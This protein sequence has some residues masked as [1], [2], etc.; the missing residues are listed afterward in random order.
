MDAL[1]EKAGI[2]R[3]TLAYIEEGKSRPTLKTLAKLAGAIGV[4]LGRLLGRSGT[5]SGAAL[6]DRFERSDFANLPDVTADDIEW[7]RSASIV[8][9]L[10]DEPSDDAIYQAMR[11]RK[12]VRG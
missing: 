7:L 5:S 10:G 6:A 12:L 8:E 2:H 4:D 1:A 11:L 9:W 3:N